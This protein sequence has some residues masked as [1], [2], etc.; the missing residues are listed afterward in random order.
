MK[1]IVLHVYGAAEALRYEEFPDPIPMAGEVLVR[2]AATSINP[3][4]LRMRSGAVKALFPLA[5]P[6]ILGL[7]LS[8]TVEAVGPG[9]AGFDHGDK[10]FAH[11][12]RTY[13]S[14]CVVKSGMLA[15]VPR[16]IDLIESA[17][18]PTVTTTGAQLAALALRGGSGETVLVAGAVGNVGRSAVCVARERGA[19]VIAGVL[20]RQRDEALALGADHMVALDDTKNLDRLP[21]LDAVADTI[22]GP[23]ADAL[24]SKVKPGGVFASVLGPPS[25]AAKHPE[26]QIKTMQ[27]KADPETLLRMAGAVIE[28]RLTIP[29]GPRFALKDAARAHAAAEN[30]VAGKILLVA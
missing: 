11:T 6:A 20:G 9:V 24:I 26:I 21:S 3:I 8:G 27:V 22:S 4:D 10:V 19:T 18:L 1:A 12:A 17:A 25:T 7:D 15:K 30:G 5:F 23:L 14:H 28:R 2:I 13:A 29:L 16:G